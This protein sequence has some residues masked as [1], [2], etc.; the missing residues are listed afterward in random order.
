MSALIRAA[1]RRAPLVLC[2]LALLLLVPT[3]S[4]TSTREELDGRAP[5]AAELVPSVEA[6][7]AEES[8]RPGATATLVHW[9]ADGLELPDDFSP[10]T[11]AKNKPSTREDIQR[12]H[13]FGRRHRVP[14]GH[15]IDRRTYFDPCSAGGETGQ[16]GHNVHNRAVHDDVVA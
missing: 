14:Q 13:L 9:H 11:D 1:T 4:A 5:T 12:R 7:F 3:S 2:A 16:D 6:A 15:E 8:Y 10:D